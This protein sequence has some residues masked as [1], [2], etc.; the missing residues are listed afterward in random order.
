MTVE[1]APTSQKMVTVEAPF[2][3]EISGKAMVK[4]L[5]MKEQTKNM[6]KL[7]FIW[8][9]AVLKITKQTCETIVFGRTGKMGVVD[10]KIA[11]FLQIKQ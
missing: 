3:E 11:R 5:D 10:F 7:I 9:K 4:M 1:V 8:N 2:I 6:I